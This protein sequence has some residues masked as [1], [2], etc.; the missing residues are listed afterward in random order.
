MTVSSSLSSLRYVQLLLAVAGLSRVVEWWEAEKGFW[1]FADQKEDVEPLT[2]VLRPE[3][4]AGAYGSPV[5]VGPSTESSLSHLG[6][7]GATPVVAQSFPSIKLRLDG[8]GTSETGEMPPS[9][10]PTAIAPPED[11]AYKVEQAKTVNLVLELSLDGEY[12]EWI[13]P[14]WGEVVG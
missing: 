12:V 8:A 14:A 5:L 11:L 10:M 13:N 6:L 4:K 9:S 2:F 7:S 3:P 1:N